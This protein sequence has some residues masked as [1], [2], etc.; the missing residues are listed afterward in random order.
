M[1]VARRKRVSLPEETEA[2]P[3]VARRIAAH[4]PVEHGVTESDATARV[5][6]VELT[7]EFRERGIEEI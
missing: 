5:H 1:V 3:Q 7:G 4:A 2:P 6:A